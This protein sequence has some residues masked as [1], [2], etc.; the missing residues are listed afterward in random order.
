MAGGRPKLAPWTAKPALKS[1]TSDRDPGK[2][3]KKVNNSST[4]HDEHGYPHR[5]AMT[6]PGLVPLRPLIKLCRRGVRWR[7][8]IHACQSG[9]FSVITQPSTSKVSKEPH[10]P[11]PW[12][13]HVCMCVTD[14]RQQ[15][16]VLDYISAKGFKSPVKSPHVMV[17]KKSN[18]AVI[19]A[20]PDLAAWLDDAAF[21]GSL[22]HRCSFDVPKD[23]VRT[24]EVSLLAAV[25]DGLCPRLLRGRPSSGLSILYGQ[26]DAILPGLW[27]A[28][29]ASEQ[30][31][32]DS[33][34][35]VSVALSPLLGDFRA[36]NVTIPLANT[37]FQNGRRSTL[38]A[39]R[40]QSDGN[41]PFELREAMGKQTQAIIPSLRSIQ[42]HTNASVPLLPVTRPRKIVTGLGNIVRQVEID[43]CPSPASKE[44]EVVIPQL[45]K[46]RREK[47][48]HGA[49]A[50]G[51]PVAVWALVI[52]QAAMRYSF[53][54]ELSTAN[55]DPDSNTE[56]E[57]ATDISQSGPN[58]LG[59]G[60]H[61]HRIC[62][63]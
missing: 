2:K 41:G 42:T 19:L 12:P 32:V 21:L 36:L 20:S 7:S 63:C 47:L 15:Q 60:C 11:K 26:R 31:P 13:P 51:G 25:V 46:K 59:A 44:L 56:V 28:E 27:D 40:W 24:R 23:E 29:E 34:A 48:A 18:A 22:L 3:K 30:A 5:D 52:P 4:Q 8:S 43:G 49:A 37:L 62:K 58:L 57:I 6:T 50:A 14:T 55:I 45:L 35:S 9:R 61:F 53:V 38:L 17:T 54:E 10:A 1:V 16:A 33:R 39:S